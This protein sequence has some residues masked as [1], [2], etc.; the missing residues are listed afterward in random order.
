M[1]QKGGLLFLS[2]ILIL[3]CCAQVNNTYNL[4][5]VPAELKTNGN[6]VRI[7]NQFRVSIIGSANSRLYTE[8]SRFVRRLS[9]KTGI[10]LDKQGYITQK[11]SDA[12][13]QLLLRVGRPGRLKL[14]EDESY[15]IETGKSQVIATAATDLGAIHAL[16]TLLQL[17]S[18][19]ADGY[20]FPGISIHDN[21]RFA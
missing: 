4:M 16:E 10:F 5:P 3:N 12:A 20:Y 2:I 7:T 15:A 17:V 9:N 13:A 11:D 19:D 1:A 6:S 8:A 21:P 18:T 14:G